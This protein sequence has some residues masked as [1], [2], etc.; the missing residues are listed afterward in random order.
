ML[1]EDGKDLAILDMGGQ[2]IDTG[3]PLGKCFYTIMSAFA[4]L[5]RN[6]T[7]ERTMT[8][9]AAARAR[10]RVGG[11][12]P[13]LDDK[14]RATLRSMYEAKGDD[15]KRLFTVEEIAD[16]LK[17]DRTTAY[18]YLAAEGLSTPPK[19]AKPARGRKT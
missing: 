12:K 19:P 13:K 16:T 5:E 7:R 10:G 14:G 11:R 3:T 8:G 6:M 2:A 1:Q 18:R 15:G 4:E 17:I 9:L